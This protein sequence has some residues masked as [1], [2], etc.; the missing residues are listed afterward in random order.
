MTPDEQAAYEREYL[1]RNGWTLDDN[2]KWKRTAQFSMFG[3]SRELAMLAQALIDRWTDE[4][5][6][7]VP[8]R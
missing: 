8:N 3:A 2:G 5:V 6:R 7:L 4:A 1:L